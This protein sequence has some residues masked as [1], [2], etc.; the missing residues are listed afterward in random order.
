M[1]AT[2]KIVT[3]YTVSDVQNLGI[4]WQLPSS[5]SPEIQQSI[6]N[7]IM[8]AYQ[9]FPELQGMVKGISLTKK[10]T[11]MDYTTGGKSDGYLH[12]SND[13]LNMKSIPPVEGT[14]YVVDSYDQLISHELGHALSRALGANAEFKAFKGV[15]KGDLAKLSGYANEMNDSEKFAEAIGDYLVHG[16]KAQPV[17]KEVV[18]NVRK[19]FAS[20]NGK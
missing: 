4:K 12:V 16:R 1:G 13:F 5:L 11:D 20:N 18:N 19:I 9:E 6:V 8:H 3:N 2:G 15:S 17:S 7:Q 14:Y 10:L